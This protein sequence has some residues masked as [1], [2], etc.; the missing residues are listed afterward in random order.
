MFGL[1]L[2]QNFCMTFRTSNAMLLSHAT[3][4]PCIRAYLFAHKPAILWRPIMPRCKASRGVQSFKSTGRMV[5]GCA[6]DGRRGN[7]K[8]NLIGL[9][10]EGCSVTRNIE[11]RIIFSLSDWIRNISLRLNDENSRFFE[12]RLRR[13]DYLQRIGASSRRRWWGRFRSLGWI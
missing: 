6:A 13:S 3:T 4:A 10:I 1:D 8:I 5:Q 11:A 12:Q 9:H 7:L 2:L